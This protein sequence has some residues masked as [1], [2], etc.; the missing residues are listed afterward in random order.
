MRYKQTC[1]YLLRLLETIH[2]PFLASWGKGF[3]GR[4]FYASLMRLWRANP[5]MTRAGLFV[6]GNDI[7]ADEVD[8][9]DL[10]VWMDNLKEDFLRKGLTVIIF[11]VVPA[12][13]KYL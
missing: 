10:G 11:D 13:N 6:A 7:T 2:L 9:A 1:E 12:N 4:S 3:Q 5:L 8:V